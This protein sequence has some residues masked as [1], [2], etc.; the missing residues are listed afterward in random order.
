MEQQYP[1]PNHESKSPSSLLK[2]FARTDLQGKR[3]VNLLRCSSLTQA[4]TSPEGQKRVNDAF[5]S[6]SE[7]NWVDDVFAEGVSGSQTFNREDIQELLDLHVKKPFDV[8][9]VH[10]LSRL[11][12][13]GINHGVEVEKTLKAIGVKLVSSTDLIPDGP[14]GDLIKA[15]KNYANQLQARSISLS[16]ARGL[17]LS[18]QRNARPAANRNPFALDREYLGPDGKSRMLIRWEG[19]TQLWIDPAT[20]EIKGRRHRQP[21]RPRR[22]KGERGKR[23]PREAFKGYKKQD[24]ETSRL[25]PGSRDMLDLLVWMFIAH[26][27]WKWGYRRIVQELNDRKIKTMDGKDWQNTTVK[28]ILFNP[29]YLGVEVRHRHSRALYNKVTADGTAAVF[30]DQDQLEKEERTSVPSV[31]NPQDERRLVD[32]PHLKDLLPEP[33]R[34]I[35]MKRM[36]DS[37]DPNRPVHFNKGRKIHKGE[38]GRHKHLDSQFLLTYTLKNKATQRRM[39]GETVHKKRASGKKVFR[40]YRDGGAVIRGLA[41]PNTRRVPAEFVENAVLSVLE[42][43]FADGGAIAQRVK[44]AVAEAA[45]EKP[46]DDQRREALVSEQEAIGRRM[47]LA[48]KLLTQVGADAVAE[49]MARDQAQL[50]QIAKELKAMAPVEQSQDLDPEEAARHVVANLQHLRT[51]LHGLPNAQLKRLLAAMLDNVEID[52]ATDDLTFTVLMPEWMKMPLMME[53]ADSEVLSGVRPESLPSQWLVTEA[54]HGMR[55][56]LDQW[57]C[58]KPREGCYTC[59]RVRTAA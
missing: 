57:K 35:A 8:V 43:I 54:N 46:Q 49:E 41:G 40:Y 28:N 50:E 6:L 53:K 1:Q 31:E 17:S 12:R 27:L 34:S 10:D 42:A 11:T 7:M 16:V 47:K 15:I 32:V 29:I 23:I 38:E 21:P 58:I 45:V 19:L 52:L 25:V 4:D 59:T 2:Q 5:C 22:R 36:M 39:R 56:V 26:D 20:N 9:V 14:E 30:V 44:M 13:G 37:F 48:Y 18:L 51:H 33:A 3:Y 24:D 55:L